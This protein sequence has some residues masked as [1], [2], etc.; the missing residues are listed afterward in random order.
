MGQDELSSPHLPDR[1]LAFDDVR[2]LR[3]STYVREVWIPR[4]TSP[5]G[6]DCDDEDILN[7]PFG[8]VPTAQIELFFVQKGST[9]VEF[10]RLDD[11]WHLTGRIERE[12][13]PAQAFVSLMKPYVAVRRVLTAKN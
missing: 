3:D 10:E 12:D 4:A 2:K 6:L 13:A 11:E 9:V 1:A 7:L 8:Y 5:D